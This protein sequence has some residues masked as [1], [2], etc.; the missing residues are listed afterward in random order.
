MTALRFKQEVSPAVQ[1][2]AMMFF[3]ALLVCVVFASMAHAGTGGGDG[4]DNV[5]A[6]ISEYLKGTMGRV[7]VGLIV[8]VG[9]AAGVVRQSLMSFAVAV[10]AAIGLFYSPEIIEG[11]I[12]S[13]HIVEGLVLP[14]GM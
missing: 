1:K 5:W 8:I 10:G 4:F 14:I 3:V 2:Y 7:L 12:T 13:T 6:A 11:I 9:V